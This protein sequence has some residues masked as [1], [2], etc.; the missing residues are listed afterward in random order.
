MNQPQGQSLSLDNYYTF[1]AYGAI[2]LRGFL[3]LFAVFGMFMTSSVNPVATATLI[4]VIM[5]LDFFDGESFRKTH[6]N[7]I[8]HNRVQFRMLDSSI[9]RFVIHFGSI[10]LLF[11]DSNYIYFYLPILIR[12]I[13]LSGYSI[14]HYYKGYLFYPKVKAKIAAIFVGLS[15]LSYVIFGN[16]LITICINILMIVFSVIAFF[17]YKKSISPYI[18]NGK[19]EIVKGDLVE[20]L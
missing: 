17:E 6:Y 13:I 20:V 11:N 15:I 19:I 4:I 18:K 12:E 3:V 10:G 14:L 1:V 2:I 7:E 5:V 16:S 8:K 9:D